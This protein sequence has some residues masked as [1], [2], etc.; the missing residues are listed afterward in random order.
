MS[1]AAVHA[2]TFS[3]DAANS[4]VT[5]TDTLN[6]CFGCG[7]TTSFLPVADWSTPAGGSTTV[8]VD[9]FIEWTVDSGLG[10]K[11]FNVEVTLAFDSPSSDSGST[12]GQGGVGT[13]FGVFSGGFVTWNGPGTIDFDDG[14]QVVFT[15]E[16]AAV[17]G[18]G[19]TTSTGVEFVST[20]PIPLPAAGW[21]LL[22]GVGGLAAAKRRTSA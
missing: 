22:A 3:F 18:K 10:S 8:D 19:A 6:L 7:I 20:T 12:T 4:S 13:I 11:L 15:L 1:G 9:D 2:A 21:L 17:I 14:S 16:S 5:I